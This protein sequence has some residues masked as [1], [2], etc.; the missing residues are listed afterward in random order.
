[1]DEGPTNKQKRHLGRKVRVFSTF[2]MALSFFCDEKVV[3]RA[4]SRDLTAQA[5]NVCNLWLSYFLG[6]VFF[7]ETPSIIKMLRFREKNRTALSRSHIFLFQYIVRSS[8]MALSPR[9]VSIKMNTSRKRERISKKE[10]KKKKREK[11]TRRKKKE[12]KTKES[13]SFRSTPW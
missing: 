5:P 9:C 12:K 1:M 2:S 4:E 10:T 11:K 6:F 3:S 7:P 13:G 8:G